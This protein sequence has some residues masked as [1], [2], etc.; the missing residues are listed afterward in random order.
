MKS[1]IFIILISIS[2]YS[3]AAA[4]DNSYNHSDVT[5]NE[6]LSYL[7]EDKGY[8]D[9][10]DNV[11]KFEHITI[12]DGVYYIG[13]VIAK[14]TLLD[15]GLCYTNVYL[16]TISSDFEYSS[17]DIFEYSYRDLKESN[18]FSF[19]NNMPCDTTNI[20][21]N[22]FKTA[23]PIPSH[24]LYI[25]QDSLDQII[26]NEGF[27]SLLNDQENILDIYISEIRY[28][29]LTKYNDFIYY[30]TFELEG[31]KVLDALINIEND[32]VELLDVYRFI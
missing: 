2:Y 10:I 24:Q 29:Y 3:L 16:L 27:K 14:P 12:N 9:T 6:I 30:L 18:Y 13:N 22:Y 26:N 32:A 17:I 31:K 21:R 15:S 19:S 1:I 25:I 8:G 7:I 28:K 11:I 5:E 20:F 4:S 23:A